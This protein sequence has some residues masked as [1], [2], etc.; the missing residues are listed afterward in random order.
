MA[1]SLIGCS[2]QTSTQ[3]P[4]TKLK[5]IET[6]AQPA[7]VQADFPD[8]SEQVVG[9]INSNKY[10]YPSCKWAQK[11]KPGN[12]I[13]FDSIADAQKQGYE[14]CKICRPPG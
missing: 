11:I 5:T 13:T 7:R 10:H 4:E 3:Q 6:T 1:I 8:Q 9:S 2:Q 12:I 14:P